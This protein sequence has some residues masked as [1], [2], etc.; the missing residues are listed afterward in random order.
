MLNYID[1]IKYEDETED[2]FKNIV[3]KCKMDL[4]NSNSYYIYF[5]IYIGKKLF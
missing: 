5:Y 3:K 1:K 2:E 4:L